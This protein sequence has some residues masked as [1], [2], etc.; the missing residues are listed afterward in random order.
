MVLERGIRLSLLRI[1]ELEVRKRYSIAK[2][3]A[4]ADS[5][6]F[7]LLELFDEFLNTARPSMDTRELQSAFLNSFDPTEA[8]KKQA[9]ALTEEQLDSLN[10]AHR[11]GASDLLA[12]FHDRL[13]VHLRDEGI[14]HDIIDAALAKPPA[15]DLFLVVA[16]ARALA[17]FLATPDGENLVQ[18]YRRAADILHQAEEKDGVEYRYGADPKFAETPEETALFDALAQA[19]AA[20]K[21]ALAAEDFA[22]AMTHMAGLRAPIDAFFEAVQVNAE[23][24]IIRR[25]RLNLLHR[26]VEICGAVAD[27]AQLE[28]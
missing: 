28:G 13:K 6:L 12:F 2:S 4:G 16:R 3:I 25:N 23:S 9:F 8:L 15:D 11:G 1:F 7:T 20:I 17:A 5:D 14:R 24:Q 26:I 27:L 18:G 22:A 19:E 21:P 10:W